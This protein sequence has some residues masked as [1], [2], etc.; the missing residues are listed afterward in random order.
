[1]ANKTG[2]QIK[3]LAESYTEGDVIS[4]AKA[5]LWINEFLTSNLRG[6]AGIKDYQKY[7]SSIK[8]KR[9]AIPTDFIDMYKVE[10]Y[11]SS[12]MEDTELYKVYKNYDI[13]DEDISFGSDGHF[14]M[15]YFRLP[16]E[17]A[18]IGSVMTVDQVFDKP[19]ALWVAYRYLTND[20]EDN[21]VNPSLG[22]LRLQ[23]YQSE[24]KIACNDR[25][26]RFKKKHS[27]RRI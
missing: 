25:M 10:E 23:E 14:K 9:Y 3:T 7:P 8:N 15:S 6:K 16:N 26:K 2:S 13:D 11:A 12:G 20:D 27:I 1:M 21:A 22:V 4:E 17:L 24:F 19:C 18:A 5:L